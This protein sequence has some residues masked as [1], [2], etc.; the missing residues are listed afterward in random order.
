MVIHAPIK[1]STLSLS[2]REK[3]GIHETNHELS[4][5]IFDVGKCLLTEKVLFAELILRATSYT[6]SSPRQICVVN[7]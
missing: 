6:D 3:S 4:L 5:E 2:K 1:S 7:C